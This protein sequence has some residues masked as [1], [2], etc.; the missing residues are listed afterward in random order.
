MLHIFQ[1]IQ[2]LYVIF[3]ILDLSLRIRTIVTLRYWTSIVYTNDS[4]C[5]GEFWK[6][7]SNIIL[8]L[9][10]DY[11]HQRYNLN[12]SEWTMSNIKFSRFE[13]Q[14]KNCCIEFVSTQYVLLIYK[15]KFMCNNIL[16]ISIN[17][18]FESITLNIQGIQY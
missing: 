9:D 5:F 6:L 12:D 15:H 18:W 2:N 14:M 11:N 1:L 17:N 4:N 3:Q 7:F 13:K 8:I 10:E 16:N